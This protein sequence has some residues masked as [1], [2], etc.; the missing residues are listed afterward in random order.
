LKA[1]LFSRQTTHAVYTNTPSEIVRIIH[2]VGRFCM[3]IC[4]LTSRDLLTY[5]LVVV[6]E[7]RVSFTLKNFLCGDVLMKLKTIINSL[8]AWPALLILTNFCL[9]TT[10]QAYSID[11]CENISSPSDRS[12]CIRSTVAVQGGADFCYECA[13]GEEQQEKSNP[14]VDALGIIAG[15]LAYFGTNYLWSNAYKKSNQAWAGAYSHGHDACTSRFNTYTNYLT[16]RGASPMLPEQATAFSDSCNGA[17]SGMFAGGG[18]MGGNGYG[19]GGNGWGAAGYSPGFMG[20][21]IG[22]NYGG[23]MY[24][25]G[26]YG[27]GMGG[28]GYGGGGMYMGGGGGYPGNFGGGLG[29]GLGYGLGSGLMGGMMGGGGGYPGWISWRRNWFKFW[30]WRWNGW[31]SIYGRWHGNAWNGNG[32]HGRRNGFPW[33]R[34]GWNGHGLSRNGWRRWHRP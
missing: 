23:G 20:G 17:S 25:G 3:K 14:W 30:R 11:E 27:G 18:G 32:R 13:M 10:A 9:V 2:P 4:P 19:G 12:Y 21:M 28:P 33:R 7:A 22:P 31:L 24:G 5:N 6:G 1:T 34:Y 26:G 29:L 16:E 15:P 8:K